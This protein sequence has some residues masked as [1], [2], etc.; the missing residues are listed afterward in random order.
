MVRQ[1][2]KL[3]AVALYVSDL[4]ILAAAFLAAYWMRD[5]LPANGYEV[6]LP[7]DRYLWLLVI[8]LPLWSVLLAYFGLYQSFRTR[9]LWTEPWALLKAAFWGTLLLATLS[10]AFKLHYVSR[11]LIVLFGV[12]AFL[13]L[14]GERLA[15]RSIARA[16]RRKGYNY[17]NV[18]VVGT[19]RRARE[20]AQI[21]EDQKHW[22]LKLLGLVCDSAGQRGA[23]SGSHPIVGTTEEMANILRHE[24]VDEVIFAVSRKRLEEL[25]EIFLMCEELG[26]RAHVAVNFF[27]HMIA[28]VHLDDLHGVPLLTFTT[29]PYNEFLLVLK[30]AFDIVTSGVLLLVL[31]P[32]LLLIAVA[33]K[34]TSPGPVLFK[35]ARVGLNGRRFTLY[36]FRSMVQDAESRKQEILHL[37][38]MTGPVFKIKDDPRLTPIG[39]LLRRTSFDELPQLLNVFKGN[40]S[41][42]GPRPPIPEEVCEYK[43]WQRR[44][45]SMKPG[46][47]CLWQI[48]G[49]NGIVDFDRWMELDLQYIDNWSLKLDLKIF[50]KTIP[51]VLLGRGAA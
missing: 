26:I 37:N 20:I 40:M 23:R 13:L 7:F 28:K 5:A 15:V 51:A 11:L 39:K 29:T 8:I 10:F 4:A 49:R 31:S 14:S 34:A 19:G 25:E 21:V 30:R 12:A 24:V 16:A 42:V 43:S 47:T 35:Q 22:G 36:K 33:I 6:L 3:V 1:R 9:P 50:L 41:I 18:L 38:E 17:R 27:P 46:L 2:A 48:N 32:L 44:R 45:L